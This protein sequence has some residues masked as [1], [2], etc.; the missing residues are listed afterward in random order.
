LTSV[1]GSNAARFGVLLSGLDGLE[2]RFLIFHKIAVGHQVS[3]AKN[4]L[5]GLFAGSSSLSAHATAVVSSADDG[6]R[7]P[8]RRSNDLSTICNPHDN[9]T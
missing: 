7:S 2:R 4:A 1:E 8:S 3:D 6:L 9:N 5:K